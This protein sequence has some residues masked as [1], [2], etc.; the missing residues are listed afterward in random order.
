MQALL[1]DPHAVIQ[2]SNLLAVMANQ[3]RLHILDVLRQHET[4][5]GSLAIQ[6]GLSPSA[7]SQ[8]LGKL[9]GAR[10]VTT[11]REAQTIFY[12][13]KSPRVRFLLKAL[14]EIYGIEDFP[15]E[16]SLLEAETVQ[17]DLVALATTR[18]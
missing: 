3:K 12:F 9:R 5:V 6:V 17:M 15:Q 11:R 1:V 16:S 4:S 13:C 10:L 14:Y 7:L 2:A 18:E 8:H